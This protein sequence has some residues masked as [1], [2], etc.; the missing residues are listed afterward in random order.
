MTKVKSK[1][2]Y[3]L[4]ATLGSPKPVGKPKKATA[5]DLIDTD[6]EDEIA[7]ARGSTAIAN[8]RLQGMLQEGLVSDA[9]LE[10]AVWGSDVLKIKYFN[11]ARCAQSTCN[12]FPF[13]C[14]TGP[15]F[16]ISRHDVNVPANGNERL[17]LEI[18]HRLTYND[19][20]KIIFGPVANLPPA[21][22][23]LIATN[24]KKATN[25]VSSKRDE[26]F[27]GPSN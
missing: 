8:S 22:Q 26:S 10:N 7:P 24:S 21:F 14:A 5:L 23:Q 19:Q 25:V 3:D 2:S 13:Q 6:S 18:R 20:E 27:T 15:E 16:L 12:F 11:P 17:Q 9:N 1:T 4:V